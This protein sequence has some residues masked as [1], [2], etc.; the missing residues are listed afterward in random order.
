MLHFSAK[1]GNYALIKERQLNFNIQN[2]VIISNLEYL[3][4]NFVTL[5]NIENFSYERYEEN[6]NNFF[7]DE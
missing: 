3:L 2:E 6:Y 7:I 1:C 4:N 5:K